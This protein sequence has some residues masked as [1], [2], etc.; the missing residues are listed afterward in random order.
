[1]SSRGVPLEIEPLDESVCAGG[2]TVTAIHRGWCI[3]NQNEVE[4]DADKTLEITIFLS[5]FTLRISEAF[6]D[7]AVP[8]R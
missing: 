2:V 8:L 6:T 5:N 4:A 3:Q 1:M 7:V